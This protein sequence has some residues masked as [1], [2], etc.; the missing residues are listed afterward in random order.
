M[1]WTR[2]TSCGFESDKIADLVI[3]YTRGKGI[4]VGCGQR[5]VWPHVIGVDN[6]HH[7]GAGASVV[8]S[9]AYDLSIFADASL[10]FVFSS[11][12]LEHIKPEKVESTLKEWARVI[13]PG[14]YLI[15]YLPSANLYPKCQ[16][17]LEEGANPDHKW[18]IYPGDVEKKLQAVTSCGWT[19]L[20]AEERGDTN[21]Y[22]LYEVYQK[23]EDGQF[24][25]NLFQRN[26]DGKKRVLVIRYG[27]IGDQIMVSSIL[28]LLQKQGY[29]VTYNTTPEAQQVLLHD[30]HVDEWLLQDKDQVPNAQLGPYWDQF[31]NKG[32]YDKIINLC[33]SIEGSLLTL[34]GRIQHGYSPETRRKM[35]DDINYLERTHDIAGVSHK[36]HQKFYM[37]DEEKEWAMNERP[38][39]APVIMWAINGSSPHKVYPYVNVVAAWLMQNTNAHLYLVSDPTIGV[40]LQDAIML[41]LQQDGIDTSRI[42]PIGGKYKIRETLSLCMVADCVVGPETGPLNAV[43]FEDIPKVIYLSHSSRDN[44]TKHWKNAKVLEPIRSQAPCY[45]CHRL[46]FDWS[47]CHQDQESAAALCAAAIP[48]KKLFETIIEALKLRLA[49]TAPKVA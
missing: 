27:A 12:L 31:K 24:I 6:G 29:H 15:L 1:V 20:E 39:D 19:Q 14:G 45:P 8:Q 22:S 41:T 11:H 17:V 42:H 25:K 28:P 16:P 46:H 23:R 4:D 18:D 13:K 43:A 21:E 48:A 33:E 3:P 36:F 44:L 37:T 7:F 35:F 2:D 40:T 10:N 9:E 26:P 32:R 47:H 30:P 5:T 38:K 34:P 49:V